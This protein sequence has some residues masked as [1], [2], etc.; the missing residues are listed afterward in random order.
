MFVDGLGLNPDQV[1]GLEN[2]DVLPGGQDEVLQHQYDEVIL[3]QLAVL[4]LES[5]DNIT[6]CGEGLIWQIHPSMTSTVMDEAAQIQLYPPPSSIHDQLSVIINNLQLNS[7]YD[8]IT[9]WLI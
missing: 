2:I 8:N 1:S 5:V 6:D 3:G 9:A 4:A 7:K